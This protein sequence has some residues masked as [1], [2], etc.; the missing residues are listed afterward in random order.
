MA[1]YST[2]GMWQMWQT[3]K[4]V[5]WLAEKVIMQPAN[6]RFIDPFLRPTYSKTSQMVLACPSHSRTHD[7]W[8]TPGEASCAPV[9][10][11]SATV[12]LRTSSP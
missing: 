9:Y 8:Y 10:S 5:T 12:H 3:M 4:T 11:N 1:E 7:E 6:F 2:T